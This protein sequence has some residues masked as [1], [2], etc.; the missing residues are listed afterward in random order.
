M[1]RLNPKAW[2][3]VEKCSLCKSL[4]SRNP[5][6]YMSSLLVSSLHQSALSDHS[7]VHHVDEVKLLVTLASQ[8]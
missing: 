6:L 5:I 7:P 1:P 8:S 2:R 4:I 3:E